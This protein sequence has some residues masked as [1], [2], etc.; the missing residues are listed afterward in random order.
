MFTV[1]ENEINDR[2]IMKSTQIVEDAHGRVQ[3]RTT[4]PSGRAL[5]SEWVQASD[6]SKAGILWAEAVRGQIVADAAEAAHKAKRDLKERRAKAPP[7]PKI[8]APDGSQLSTAAP[9]P[10]T[11]SS[12]PSPVSANPAA[13]VRTQY[14][15][16]KS[17]STFLTGEAAR[18]NNELLAAKRAEAQWFG[19]L[20]AMGEDVGSENVPA[21][22][23]ASA[24][25][26]VNSSL[27][28]SSDPSDAAPDQDDEQ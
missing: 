28:I 24:D 19:V 7:V 18:I 1:E 2:D 11:A 14:L 5:N 9:S 25:R 3:F 27:R 21:V 22:S 6:K 4:L 13:Y 15:A 17:L 16:A 23:N 10:I 12:V 8:V 20:Q 26:D